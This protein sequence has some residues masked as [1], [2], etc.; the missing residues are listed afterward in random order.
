MPIEDKKEKGQKIEP[1]E[2]E[3]DLTPAERK[4]EWRRTGCR[5]ALRKSRLQGKDSLFCNGQKWAGSR[6]QTVQ[7]HWLGQPWESTVL[8]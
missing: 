5:S 4:T 7:T 2:C 3:E 6:T 1:F 8:V